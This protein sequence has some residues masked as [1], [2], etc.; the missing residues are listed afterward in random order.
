MQIS[1]EDL[2]TR[3]QWVAQSLERSYRELQGR[4][5]SLTAELEREREER[6]RLERHAA[7]SEMAMD[8]AHEMS[9]PL[10]RHRTLRVDA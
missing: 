6:I 4:V 3:F 1:L 7:I 2:S 10:E 5:Q 9:N 8:L